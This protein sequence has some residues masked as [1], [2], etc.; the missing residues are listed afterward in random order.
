MSRIPDHL[1]I[2][3]QTTDGSFYGWVQHASVKGVLGDE[4]ERP[5]FTH[6]I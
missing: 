6:H 5:T 3:G 1:I 4:I 2:L